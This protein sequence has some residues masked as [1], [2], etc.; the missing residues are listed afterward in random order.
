MGARSD[1]NSR[2]A[3]SRHTQRQIGTS[4]LGYTFFTKPSIVITGYLS[5]SIKYGDMNV[6]AAAKELNQRAAAQKWY[7]FCDPTL[8]FTESCYERFLALWET[9]RGERDMPRRSE[10]TPRDLK[11]FLRNIVMFQRV[12]E[13]P[14]RYSWRIIGTGVT[15]ILGHNTGKTFEETVPPEYLSRW[16]ECGDMILDGGQPLRFLGRVHINGREYLDAEHLYVPLAN[17]DGAPTYIMGLCRYTPRRSEDE[18][19]WENQIA[20]IPGGLL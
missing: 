4:Q 18:E 7:H 10:M 16:V 9:K 19:S 13:D 5:F 11:D 14:S 12:S 15:E 17:D 2:Y 3:V 6:L 1:I 20:S 8:A